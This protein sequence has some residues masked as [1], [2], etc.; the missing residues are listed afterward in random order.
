MILISSALCQDKITDFMAGYKFQETSFTFQKKQGIQLFFAV[1]NADSDLSEIAR[2][3]K[4]AIKQQEWGAVL[5]FQC[6]AV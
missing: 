2:A 3:V 4:Q 5:F 1:E 6:V